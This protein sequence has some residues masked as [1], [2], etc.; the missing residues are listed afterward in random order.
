MASMTTQD[1]MNI[2]EIAE[3]IGVSKFRIRSKSWREKTGIPV[4]K[5]G[6]ELVS[7]RPILDKWIERRLNG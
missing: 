1:R 5:L 2:K 4:G 3:Y 6:K 7:Y